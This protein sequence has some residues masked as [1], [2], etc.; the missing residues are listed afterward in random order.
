MPQDLIDTWA[1]KNSSAEQA[2]LISINGANGLKQTQKLVNEKMQDMVKIQ[3]ELQ[4]TALR[5]SPGVLSAYLNSLIESEKDRGADDGM[6][7]SLMA[8]K[9]SLDISAR[10][11]EKQR[12]EKDKE[13]VINE[14]IRE[15]VRRTSLKKEERLKEENVPNDYYNR[16]HDMLPHYMKENEAV[17]ERL[18]KSYKG[19]GSYPPFKE[20]L[21]RA[22][23]L[24]RFLIR[25]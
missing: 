10:G 9:R 7:N 16:L 14:I 6:I 12:E 23:K 19:L 21:Q 5:N 8:A 3:E 1:G 24:L 18:S 20:S 4:K 2:I 17:P 13:D 22:G 25:I 11:E 15:L